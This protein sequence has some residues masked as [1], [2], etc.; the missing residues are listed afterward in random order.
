MKK[1]NQNKKTVLTTNYFK[2]LQQGVKQQKQKI[3]EQFNMIEELK[4]ELNNFKIS[5]MTYPIPQ[6]YKSL[7]KGVFDLAELICNH[8]RKLL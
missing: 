7:D 2:L 8:A 3:V 6:N 5:I 4:K 1:Q